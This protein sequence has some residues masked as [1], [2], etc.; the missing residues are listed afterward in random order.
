MNIPVINQIHIVPI[1]L[2]SIDSTCWIR[3]QGPAAIPQLLEEAAKTK[4]PADLFMK[5]FYIF[6]AFGQD[7]YALQMQAKA[8][9]FRKLFR[10]VSPNSVN[11]KLLALVTDGDIMDNTP[12]DFLIENSDIQ[13]ELLYVDKQISL[14]LNVPEHDVMFLAIGESPKNSIILDRLVKLIQMWPRPCINDPMAIKRCARDVFYRLM[15]SGPHIRVAHT[16][17]K[18]RDE[19][20]F[21]SEPFTIRPVGS[22]AGSGFVKI[23]S[24]SELTAYLGSY[25]TE[26]VYYVAE[27]IDY[28][29]EDGK[30]RK[31]RI[32]LI[33]GRPFI[34]HLAI[35]DHWI[36]HYFPSGME[37][38]EKKRQEEESE[39]LGFDDGFALK[40][41]KALLF[42]YN[43][44]G[45]DY[46]VID[47]AQTKSGELL[48]FEADSGSW[49]HATD[50]V[51]LFP[52]KPAI[53]QKAFD[54]FRELLVKKIQGMQ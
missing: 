54:A 22:H 6:G 35:S 4:D 19:I 33:G 53:M 28:Q 34:C 30:Y 27:F 18:M 48:V 8:L 31:Y 15:Q 16:V 45:L 46:V 26:Q 14:P 9:E 39:M 1:N 44:L 21:E 12:L 5:M 52:Y 49:I 10:T 23:T 36:V 47:C 40:H 29:S 3:R 2:E 50:P 7:G 17:Q 32:A 25:R 41:A 24:Q 51:E 43:S 20:S 42:V 37:H 13:L 38:S 11:I